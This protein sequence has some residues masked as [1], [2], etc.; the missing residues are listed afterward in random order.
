MQTPRLIRP[1]LPERTGEEEAVCGRA[2]RHASARS[3]RPVA[4]VIGE[5]LPVELEQGISGL[6]KSVKLPKTPP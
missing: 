2:R 6:L 3:C 5:G 1:Y 4:Q